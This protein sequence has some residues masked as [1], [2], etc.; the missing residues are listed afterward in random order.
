M[1]VT[2][3][4][5]GLGAISCPSTTLAVGADETCTATYTTTQADVDAG[6]ITN[7]G[8]AAGTPPSGPTVTASDSL[9]I[10][11]TQSPSIGI[12]K[13][14]SI[15]GFSAAGTP[16][17]YSYL[18]TNTG[19]VTLSNVTV[20][21]PMAGLGAISCP[22]GNLASLAPGATV[23]CTATYTTTQADVDAGSI[24]NIGTA[25]GTPPSGPPVTNTSTVTIPA[26]QTPAISIVKSASVSGYSAPGTPV[27]YSYLVTNTGNVTLST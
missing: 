3:P 22:G 4:M 27:T 8:T 7:T 20:T 15:S 24:T 26:S 18:V 9:T 11:A 14:A 23:T 6:S 13:T 17:T 19:N 5:V 10:P 1:S 25:T 16:V 21:D 2:D 12:D